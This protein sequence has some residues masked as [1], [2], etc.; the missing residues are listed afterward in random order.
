MRSGFAHFTIGALI[1]MGLIAGAVALRSDR[2]GA[3]SGTVYDDNGTGASATLKD[4]PNPPPTYPRPTRGAQFFV[5][6]DGKPQGD[7]S[8]KRPWDLATALSQPE[9]VKPGDT[10]WLRS[11]TYKGDFESKL[12][13]DEV[14]PIL[15]S[16]SANERA[17]IDGSLTVDGAWTTFWGFEVMD[18]SPDRANERR[19]GVEV[20]GPHTKFINLIVHDCG[21][22]FGFWS[23]AVEAELYGNIVFNN[24][25]QGLDRGHGH[26]IYAQ[27]E[28]GLKL[29]RDN[30][31]FNQFGLGIHAY[32]ERG[33]LNG[34]YFEGNVSFNNGAATREGVRYDN[35]LIGGHR[36]A[37]R[38]SLI[39]NLTYNT[40]TKT[41]TKPNVR[42]GYADT[43]N[44][45]LTMKHNY[46]AGGDLLASF[47][48]WE[49]AT[50]TGNT[51][52]GVE[53]LLDLALPQGAA[54][55]NYTW[56]N[57]SYYQSE[58]GAAFSLGGKALDFAGWRRATGF[59]ENSTWVTSDSGPSAGT[60]IFIRQNHYEP[61]RAHIVV[62]N[63]GLKNTV[64]IDVKSLLTVGESYEV[65][66]VEHFFGAP[67][68]SGTFDGGPL[69][70]PMTGIRV[71]AP[72]GSR[73]APESTGPMFNV[74]VLLRGPLKGEG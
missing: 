59:D 4:A 56:N 34:L 63:W 17:T 18:S 35:I 19:T 9:K 60:K 40:F 68:L 39:N 25:W 3:T 42:L 58:R 71:V 73:A 62:Y 50:V 32:T 41:D 53:R 24:G 28:E 33:A 66:S 13:G 45:D 22:G 10:I 23:S 31:T 72:V 5:A 20:Y 47:R 38:I 57:N 55:S 46:F 26:G 1:V 70:L 30:I 14:Q 54:A 65:R 21:N 7:G 16:Q 67:V 49:V 8:W 27:N 6:P 44:K 36:P 61:E 74:F 2:F 11:G 69:P 64:D 52:F 12:T 51:F 15:V 48:S 37:E 29:I 43:N